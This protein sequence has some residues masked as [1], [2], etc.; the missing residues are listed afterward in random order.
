[1]IAQETRPIYSARFLD[2]QHISEMLL[3]LALSTIAICILVSE[4]G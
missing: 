2:Y 4:V 3:H 1:M